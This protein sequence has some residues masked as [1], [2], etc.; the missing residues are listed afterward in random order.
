MFADLRRAVGLL[1]VLPVGSSGDDTARRPGRAMAYFPL[2]GAA[3]G[4]VLA[5][6]AALLDWCD[7]TVSAP[8]LT[9]AVLT[10]VWAGLTGALHLD[11][12]AD[13]CDAL[14]VPVDRERRLEIMKDPRLGG[15]GATGL[16]LLLLVKFA[17]I[18]GVLQKPHHLVMLVVVAAVARW[19]AVAAAYWFKPARPGGMG[20]FF[21]TGLS[22]F[23][24][25]AATVMALAV[26]V[27]LL[28]RG[29]VVWAAVIV[30][31]V[32]VA[33]VARS[34]LGGLTG[35]VYGAVI[36]FGE[37]LALVVLCLV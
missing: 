21:R 3:V 33:S 10:A 4:G 27:P 1:T 8:L 28:W 11:G 12:W 36:E 5:G 24:V 23:V 9:A 35:D 31:L 22:R 34:R 32:V 30:S 20:S 2:V 7:A 13:C 18:H 19:A 37:T 16:I 25:L 15:F 17:A 26:A 6:V 29:A 14:L